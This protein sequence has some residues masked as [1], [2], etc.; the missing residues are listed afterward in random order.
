MVAQGT[1][2]S[3]SSPSKIISTLVDMA[4]IIQQ[5][6][7]YTSHPTQTYHMLATSLLHRLLAVCDAQ[8]GAIV[9]LPQHV[10]RQLK[11]AQNSTLLREEKRIF[12]IHHISE[13]EALALTAQLISQDIELQ[14]TAE[15]EYCLIWQLPL[16]AS[17]HDKQTYEYQNIDEDHVRYTLQAFLLLGWSGSQSLQHLTKG[18]RYL[19]LLA[20]T[21]GSVIAHITMMEHV[22]D[23]EAL[24]DHHA[25]REMELLKAELLATVSHELR[26]PLASIKGYAATLLRHEHRISREERHEFLVAINDSSDHME[27]VINRLLEISQLETGTVNLDKTAVNLIYLV[28]EAILAME[29]RFLPSSEQKTQSNVEPT[30][31]PHPI[32]TLN[33]KNIRGQSTDEGLIIYADRHRLRE[34]FDNLFENAVLYTGVENHVEVIIRPLLTHSEEAQNLLATRTT[35]VDMQRML[36]LQDH[37][38]LIHIQVCDQGIGIPAGQL[39]RIFDRFYRVDT[40]LTREV[41]GLGLGLSICKRI[42]EL[43]D[44]IIW[45]DSEL[46]KGSTFHIILPA[47]DMT[48]EII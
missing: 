8:Q 4:H 17:V 6:G 42:I 25:L 40:R 2:D 23:L 15:Q 35:T 18:R 1:K 45:V 21:A 5:A 46:G 28:R 10:V 11:T 31:E 26:S 37:P 47:S 16:S 33:I 43:H 41:N 3:S 38:Q 27:G 44:G 14:K 13:H 29:Q 32:F 34:L 9:L 48:S 22:H 12:A 39:E 19:P 30:E 36:A 20:E 7:S 24:T